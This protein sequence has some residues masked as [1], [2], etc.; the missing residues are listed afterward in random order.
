M[1]QTTT[2][3]PAMPHRPLPSAAEMY[4]AIQARDTRYDGVFFTAVRTTGIFCR[5]GCPAKTPLARNVEFFSSAKEALAHGYRPCKRCK[6]LEARG[7]APRYIKE[8]LAELER[9]PTKRIRDRDLRARGLEPAT[10]RRWFNEH[11]RMTFHAYQRSLRLG[12]ALRSL[13]NGARITDAAY[14]SGYDSLSGFQEALKQITGKSASQSRD[15]EVVW[16]SRVTTPVGPMLLGAS[17]DG[18]CLLEFTDRRMLETQLK[19]IMAKLKCVFLP[20]PNQ[21]TEQL[22]TELEEYFARRLREF[23]T[24]LVT[25]GT[26]FQMRTWSALRT[27]GYGET[28]SYGQQA[29]LMGVPK[30]VRAVARA[31]GDNRIA[32]VIP[33]HRVV[34]ADGTLTG[35]GG[36]L[37]RKR[38]LLHHEGVLQGEET[39]V[40]GRQLSLLS[41]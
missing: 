1:P 7:E 26:D 30:A 28:R 20:G 27:I 31:N 22:E 15:A 9:E 18:V 33:C 8:L 12:G 13:S 38:W 23:V 11:H 24:P 32:I 35:Y 39:V 17:R 34:G 3:I 4:A 41:S 5:P 2:A 10:V 16:L 36:G 19:R 14:T 6:P 21:W 37:W 40:P 25:V 29:A